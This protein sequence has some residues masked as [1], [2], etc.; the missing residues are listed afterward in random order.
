MAVPDRDWAGGIRPGRSVCFGSPRT[1]SIARQCIR[2]IRV[3]RGC[4]GSPRTNHITLPRSTPL[5]RPGNFCPVPVALPS[6]PACRAVLSRRSFAKAE[7]TRR[8]VKASQTPSNC[9]FAVPGYFLW[10]NQE[11]PS[12][13]PK[14]L[15]HPAQGWPIQR[16]LPWVAT[17]EP[18]NPER[19]ESPRHSSPPF[20]SPESAKI[21]PNQAQS[22][23][24]KPNRA[25]FPCFDTPAGPTAAKF[26]NC[27][28]PRSVRS[29]QSDR[30]AN[31]QPCCADLSAVLSAEAWAEA[32]RLRK[33]SGGASPAKADPP[34]HHSTPPFHYST[35]PNSLTH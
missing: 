23:L 5:P 20:I 16:G 1:N 25:I 8:R 22:S 7:A 18:I 10:A 34:L 13:I 15:N 24:T 35:T 21:K 17:T 4:T 29:G 33:P 2:V 6:N 11:R 14:G 30:A 31:P 12:S 28:L 3:I 26:R 32:L 9:F 19:V 27:Q